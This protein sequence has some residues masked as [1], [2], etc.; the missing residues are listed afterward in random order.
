MKTIH[1]VGQEGSFTHGAALKRYSGK[2][3][4][5][6]HKSHH[7]LVTSLIDRKIPEGEVSVVPLW[8]SNTGIINMKQATET[9]RVFHGDATRI[10]DLWPHRI[11]FQLAIPE[12]VFNAASR[13]FS[14]KVAAYQCSKFL[15]Q[16]GV[17]A[18]KRFIESNTTTEAMETFK[19]DHKNNDGILC[20]ENLLQHHG[21]TGIP[22]VSATNANNMTIFAT[23]GGL[24][25]DQ[26]SK[27]E[28]V[29]GCFTTPVEGHELPVDFIDYYERLVTHSLSGQSNDVVASIPKIL[30]I[31][32]DEKSAKVLMLL[33]MPADTDGKGDWEAPDVETTIDVTEVGELQRS[34]TSQAS[35]LMRESFECNEYCFYGAEGCYMWICPLLQISVHG[36]DKDLVRESARMQVL[37]LRAL[38]N[39]G[40]KA[41]DEVKRV[42]RFDLA[43]LGLNADSLPISP[44]Q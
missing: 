14:V 1:I 38:I 39:E 10:R 43:K 17:L 20:D 11:L 22:D 35:N 26:F 4:F 32:R 36:Y 5:V 29:L 16:H 21:Y 7:D 25:N 44:N 27:P 33:E 6:G 24:P 28:W 41:S 2:Q 9:T 18:G 23:I 12:G 3:K 37:R 30:F 8:N 40:R 34:Y 31:V 19:K 15:E 42:L 13:I